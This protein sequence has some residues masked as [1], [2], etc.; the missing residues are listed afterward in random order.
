MSISWRVAL[1]GGAVLLAAAIATGAVL[2]QSSG[3]STPT[4]GGEATQPKEGPFREF[5]A[6]LADNLGIPEQQLRD[7]A[8]QTSL[9]LLDEAVAEGRI[10][11]ERPDRIRERIESG[12][13]A[14]FP[15]FGPGR[16]HKGCVHLT[17]N[18]AE[19]LGLT[20]EEL[21]DRRQ[22]GDTLGEIAEEQGKSRDELKGLLLGQLRERTQQAVTDGKI[23]QEQADQRLQ[24]AEQRI[25]QLIDR[26][27][28]PRCGMR[29]RGPDG[30]PA[31]S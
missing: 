28:A 31:E 2:A 6:R 30:A 8:R 10:D 21:R 20:P 17:S 5:M 14:P 13:G 19:F 3:D 24:E 25:D 18:V 16:H 26:E 15:F 1:A 4:P 22:A 7:A 29:H 23:T 12:E 11:Q 27:G 9:E